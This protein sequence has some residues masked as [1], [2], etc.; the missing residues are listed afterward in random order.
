MKL[1]SEALALFF[2]FLVARQFCSE[3]SQFLFC[4][5]GSWAAH[6]RWLTNKG[7]PHAMN[8]LYYN[9]KWL[10]INWCA[11]FVVC[12]GWFLA[13]CARLRILPS[14]KHQSNSPLCILRS[15]TLWGL[16]GTASCRCKTA[17]QLLWHLVLSRFGR[18]G[19]CSHVVDVKKIRAMVRV[20]VPYCHR[21]LHSAACD[22]YSTVSCRLTSASLLLIMAAVGSFE[23]PIAI[24]IWLNDMCILF[25][26]WA[27]IE[28]LQ[29]FCLSTIW[30]MKVMARLISFVQF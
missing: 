3:G 10:S 24:K 22:R 14:N 23:E 20:C 30:W 13:V 8:K 29:R 5:S 9:L 12:V 21:L 7:I 18:Y 17:G 28:T 19:L 27:L 6:E 11:G 26:R 16:W 15:T 1:F 25:C 2:I 4:F